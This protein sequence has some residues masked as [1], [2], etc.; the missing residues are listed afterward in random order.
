MDAALSPDSPPKGYYTWHGIIRAAVMVGADA[1]RW[2]AIDRN[3][4]LAWGIHGEARPVQD[5]PNN[6]GLPPAR[7]EQLRSTWLA[8]SFDDLDTA[9]DSEPWPPGFDRNAASQRAPSDFDQLRAPRRPGNDEHQP[10]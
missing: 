9:F 6:P 2:L 10:G 3:V 8:F 7:L 1:G 4:G 5:A